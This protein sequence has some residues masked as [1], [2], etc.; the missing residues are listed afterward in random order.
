VSRVRL[1]PSI[2]EYDSR[3]LHLDL[4]KCASDKVELEVFSEYFG[5][6]SQFSFLSF[7]LYDSIAFWTFT[8]FFSFLILH[9][10]GRTPWTG[11]QPVA[12]PLPTHGTTQTQNKRTQTSM[13]QAGFEPMTAVFERAKTVRA[14]DRATTVI[15]GSHST[16]C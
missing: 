2:S 9:T 13:P 15:G 4:V 3:A 5:F 10:I 11:D 12:R 14:S 6:P 8:P 7:S 16:N 1:E